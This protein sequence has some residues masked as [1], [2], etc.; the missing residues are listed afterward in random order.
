MLNVN[1]KS[2]YISFGG[3]KKLPDIS[4]PVAIKSADILSALKS[5]NP[6]L[7]KLNEK[8]MTEEAKR[9]I[10]SLKKTANLDCILNDG[11]SFKDGS[12]TVKFMTPDN[13]TLIVGIIQNIKKKP[14]TLLVKL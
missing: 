10:D 2:S 4:Y 5:I 13:Y 14:R 11:I 1:N 8:R 12:K 6:N 7:Q 3:I 9:T